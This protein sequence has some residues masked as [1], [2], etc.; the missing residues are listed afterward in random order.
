MPKINDLNLKRWKD[1]QDL[2]TDSLWLIDERGREAGHSGEYHGNFVPQIPHQLMR[3]FTKKGEVVLDVFLGS[4]TTLLEAD[5]LGRKSIGVELL[6]WLAKQTQKRTRG[7]VVAG[8]S[9]KS[10]TRQAVDDALKKIKNKSVQ[11]LVMH[12]PYHDIIKFSNR[13]DDLSNATSVEQFV[14]QFGAVLDNWLDLLERHHYVAVVIGDKYTK[15]EW[16]PLGFYVMQEVLKR[17][18]MRLKSV[19]VKNMAGNR[20]KRNLEKLWRYRALK[21]GFYVFK[22]EYILLF[23]KT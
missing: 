8:D 20:A 15:S 1:Y 23:Q 13:K 17:K 2:W 16:V 21:G 14:R 11:L 7:I 12:P 6:P 3:R 22:H 10:K 18:E 19:V 5:R 4:G 9:A